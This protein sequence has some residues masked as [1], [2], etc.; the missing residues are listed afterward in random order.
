MGEP[1]RIMSHFSVGN[2]CYI[3]WCHAIGK[4]IQGLVTR[5]PLD[6]SEKH[7]RGHSNTL[8]VDV[9]GKEIVMP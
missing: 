9:S 3:S 8:D 7:I 6:A 2:S 1:N 4:G 5:S